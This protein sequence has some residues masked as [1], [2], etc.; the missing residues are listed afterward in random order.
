MTDLKS[1]DALVKRVTERRSKAKSTDIDESLKSAVEA[2]RKEIREA[3]H[4]KKATPKF[5]VK[6]A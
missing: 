5:K 3:F 6:N 1:L 2:T 4:T